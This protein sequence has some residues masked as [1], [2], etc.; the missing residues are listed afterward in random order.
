MKQGYE[1]S[2]MSMTNEI[3]DDYAWSH[4]TR[5]VFQYVEEEYR[6]I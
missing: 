2:I 3:L 4:P 6:V 5:Q 1:I